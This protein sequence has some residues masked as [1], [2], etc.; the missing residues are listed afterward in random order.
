MQS[1]RYT[2][3]AV[4]S[5][6]GGGVAIVAQYALSPV[7]GADA[8]AADLLDRVAA[9]HTAM[10][11]ALALDVPALLAVPAI[12]FIGAL[13]SMRTSRLA[14]VAAALL[15][16]PLLMSLPPVF[17][18]DGL[19]YFASVAP[20]RAAMVSLVETWQGSAYF[21]VGLIPYVVCQF[22]GSVMM[23]AALLRAGTVPR[24]VAAAV[25]VWPFVAT[26]GIVT[27]ATVLGLAG[28]VVLLTGWSGA[29]VSV[30]RAGTT[31]SAEPALQQ[32]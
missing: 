6:V 18:F 8:G 4:V 30:V 1:S 28:Y 19:V 24:W 27:G 17:G 31:S 11:W 29:A 16:F 21:A 14:A 7:N 20:D 26:A 5:L 15:F 12:L 10:G 9:H 25:G 2:I 13:G 3:A 22:V 23:A 32:A